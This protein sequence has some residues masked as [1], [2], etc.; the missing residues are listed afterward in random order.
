MTYPGKNLKKEVI[1]PIL[2][3]SDGKIKIGQHFVFKVSD[4]RTLL[5][6]SPDCDYVHIHNRLDDR[7]YNK[8]VIIPYKSTDTDGKEKAEETETLNDTTILLEGLPCPP[9]PNCPLI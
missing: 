7:G 8:V 1:A 5:D 4:L 2:D 3:I 6:A 9:H